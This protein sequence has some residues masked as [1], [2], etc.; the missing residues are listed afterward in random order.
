MFYFSEDPD[1]YQSSLTRT[2]IQ[3]ACL[4]AFKTLP[5]PGSKQYFFFILYGENAYYE[6]QHY[7]LVSIYD[8]ACTY[9]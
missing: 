3:P 1:Q 6:I 8:I 2:V 4:Y 7:P 5:P 9:V